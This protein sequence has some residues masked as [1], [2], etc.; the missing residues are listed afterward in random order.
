[1]TATDSSAGGADC[2]TS[3]RSGRTSRSCPGPCATAGRWSTSTPGPPRSA[4]ARCW[5]PSGRSW[6]STTR[7]C[8]AA[9]TSWPRRPPTPTRRPGPGS[10]RSSGRARRSWCSPRTPPRA[11]TWS[12]TPSRTRRSSGGDAERFVLRPGDE[13]V[14]TELEHHANLVPWQELCRRT[15][16]TLRW[17]SVTDDGRLDLDSIELSERTRVV[18]VRPPVQRAVHRA[19]GGRAGPAGPRGRARWWCWTPASRCRTSR[20]T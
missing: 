11:S 16:A 9:R 2:W 7:P 19:A 18:A 12:P 3:R 14:V 5:T 17:Y 1:M 13:I 4:R 10:P 8:T 20:C 15:G 6:S